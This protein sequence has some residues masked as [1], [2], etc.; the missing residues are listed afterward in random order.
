MAAVHSPEAAAYST[1]HVANRML[2]G[3]KPALNT[4]LYPIPRVTKENF[5][6]FY[7]PSMTVSSLCYPRSPDG[8]A[9]PDSYFDALFT[10]GQPVN[11]NPLPAA[12]R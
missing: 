12:A 7:H 2:A 10:G 5:D 9:V 1:F 11:T 8:R 4:L 6:Q 3:Q